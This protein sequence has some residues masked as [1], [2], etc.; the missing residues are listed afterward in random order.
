MQSTKQNGNIVFDLLYGIAVVGIEVPPCSIHY[1][2]VVL[3]LKVGESIQ[4]GVKVSLTVQFADILLELG[5]GIAGLPLEAY[6]TR[7][8]QKFRHIA[9]LL[10]I[11]CT[12]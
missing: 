9:Q 5:K 4:A 12:P 10:H 2:G 7:K 8:C 1:G 11:R 6:L 3:V